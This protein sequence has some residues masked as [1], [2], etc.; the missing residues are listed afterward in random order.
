MLPRG[1]DILSLMTYE[2][3]KPRNLA[4]KQILL[5]LNLEITT[6]LADIF[7]ATLCQTLRQM[8][9]AKLHLDS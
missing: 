7:I 1:T 5:K 8:S 6:D 4:W 2:E 9:P 3:Q